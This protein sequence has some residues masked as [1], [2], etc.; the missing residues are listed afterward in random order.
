[1]AAFDD[2]IVDRQA[3]FDIDQPGRL[4]C[5]AGQS[6][7]DFF[8]AYFPMLLAARFSHWR[9][10]AQENDRRGLTNLNTAM[11]RKF[12]ALLLRMGLGGLR[13]RSFYCIEHVEV[14]AMSQTTFQNIFYTIRDAG[15]AAYEEEQTLPDGRTAP[16]DDPPGTPYQWTLQTSP[17][18]HG[19]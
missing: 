6:P 17:N 15:F 3:S 2:Q 1:V 7:I 12:L 4:R 19:T 8:G 18:T 10:H 14:A 5:I 9:A 13:R 16:A 11:F